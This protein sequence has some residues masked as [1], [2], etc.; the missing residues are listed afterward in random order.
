MVAS[1]EGLVFIFYARDG[2]VVARQE[3]VSCLHLWSL[4][5]K[6]SLA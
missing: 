3:A 1:Q 4:A 5:K 6:P 2:A